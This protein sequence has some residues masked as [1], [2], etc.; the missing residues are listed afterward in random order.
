MRYST[1][2]IVSYLEGLTFDTGK[3]ALLIRI[4]R[5]F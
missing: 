1:N 5:E 3:E 4:K 2:I